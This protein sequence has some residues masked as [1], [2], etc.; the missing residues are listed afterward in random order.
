MYAL[1]LEADMPEDRHIGSD[2]VASG[3]SLAAQ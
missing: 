2:G 3:V 1:A